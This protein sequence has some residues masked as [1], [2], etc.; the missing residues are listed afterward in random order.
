MKVLKITG[1]SMISLG[2][3]ILLFL[4]YQLFFTNLLTA[5]AQDQASDALTT[6]FEELRA[7]PTEEVIVVPTTVAPA[8][9]GSG[10]ASTTP[11]NAVTERAEPISFFPEESPPLGTEI[12]RI[13]IDAID[14]DLVV[15][16][17]V[18]PPNLKKGPGHMSWTPMPGQP[19]NSVISGHRVTNG[20]PFF[21][22]N[23]LVPG[24][25]ITVET[26]TGAHVYEVREILIVLPTDVWVT[27]PRPG[28]W[29]TLT[30]C[31]PRFS[32]R[33]RLVIVAELVEG[34][35]VEYARALKDGIVDEASA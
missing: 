20:A 28:A 17:G 5:R 29:L 10:E 32:A 1:W 4:V 23:E 12:G 3:L 26:V 8:I 34:P 33:E 24:D 13:T 31:N 19:G 30:T 18:D 25:R 16:Q 6:R 22:L 27:N 15:V 35:N 9:V 7:E 2:S 14:M 21:Y 11:T